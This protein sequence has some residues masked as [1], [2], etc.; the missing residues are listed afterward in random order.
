MAEPTESINI[1]PSTSAQEI[2]VLNKATAN[3]DA[4]PSGV[5]GLISA[6]KV[7][8]SNT[9]TVTP[10]IAK[11]TP[12]YNTMEADSGDA[13]IVTASELV[14]GNKSLSSSNVLQSDIDVTNFETVSISAMPVSP[15]DNTI[16]SGT[17][18]E[19][20]TGDYA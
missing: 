2:D 18:Y 15:L 14:E 6:N 13:I 4:M 11:G 16:I 12:G 1:T 17:A 10:S 9:A 8:S 7:I 19:E 20:Q 5:I 3:V